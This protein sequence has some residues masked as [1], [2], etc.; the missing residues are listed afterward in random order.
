MNE[1]PQ[2]RVFIGHG[3][4]HVWKDLKDFLQ[5][6]LN[7]EWEEF[8]R[9]AS[10]G[11]STKERLEAMLD[12]SSFAFL[13]MTAEDE[14]GD[15]SFNARANVI[16]EI[17]LFQGR[18][19]FNRAVILLEEGC[20]EFSN[21]HGISQI[22]FP[23]GDISGVFE[24]IRRVLE[25]EGIIAGIGARMELSIVQKK[26]MNSVPEQTADQDTT[27]QQVSLLDISAEKLLSILEQ[28]PPIQAQRL[29]KASY[30]GKRVRWRGMVKSIAE[31]S[32]KIRV[33][34]L[35]ENSD[36]P[37]VFIDFQSVW[38]SKFENLSKGDKIQFEGKLENITG[39]AID[40]TEGK[41]L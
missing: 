31:L 12:S 29:A 7:L 38:L 9:E 14:Y 33:S 15:G 36:Y 28:L 41:L 10:A 20:A 2:G 22:R 37:W 32:G 24:E 5:D 19:G 8:N 21:I 26:G 27:S 6:R 34:T 17:G 18:L 23:R 30:I 11:F 25:R 1:T 16:H 13:L 35:Q 40:L 39:N 4:S 3:R